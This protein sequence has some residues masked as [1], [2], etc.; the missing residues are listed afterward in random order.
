MR[1]RKQIL[2][3]EH[4]LYT[5]RQSSSD[6]CIDYRAKTTPLPS[7]LKN[8]AIL[9]NNSNNNNDDSNNNTNN[10]SK[11]KDDIDPSPRMRRIKSVTFHDKPTIHEFIELTRKEMKKKLKEEQRERKMRS[12]SMMNNIKNKSDVDNDDD[13]VFIQEKPTKQKRS[14]SDGCLI[15][16]G[17]FLLRHRLY[18]N[19]GGSSDSDEE[20]G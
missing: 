10:I 2:L 1:N 4:R 13:E 17:S 6:N 15:I 18:K 9:C 16:P 11:N 3:A 19:G 20:G 7:I 12:K 5:G 8:I 14:F